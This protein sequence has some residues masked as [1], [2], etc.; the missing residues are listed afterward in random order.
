MKIDFITVGMF[1]ENTYFLIDEETRQCII[2]DP[3]GNR[4]EVREYVKESGLTV[5]MII[6]THGHMDHTES[7]SCVRNRFKCPILIHGADADLFEVSFDR[8]IKDGDIIKFA[9]EELKIIE[10]PGHTP[11]SVCILGDGFM[12]TGDTLFA[13]SIGRT[14]IGGDPEDMAE[15]LQNRFNGIPDSTVIYPGHGPKTTMEHERRTNR[16]LLAAAGNRL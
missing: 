10:T 6:N 12:L 13:G 9:G 5:S 1:E 14:D 3:G 16:Y 15:T 2:V 8:E 4:G 11:G 7:N